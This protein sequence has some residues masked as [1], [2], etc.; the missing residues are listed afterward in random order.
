MDKKV[1]KSSCKNFLEFQN[2]YIDI[3]IDSANKRISDKE[4]LDKKYKKKIISDVEILPSTQEWSKKF[5]FDEYK[6]LLG[7]TKIDITKPKNSVLICKKFLLWF[8]LWFKIFLQ[9]LQPVKQNYNGAQ[10]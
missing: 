7:S 3:L 8:E 10:T 9:K 4:D 2:Q 6:H 1:S 5:E